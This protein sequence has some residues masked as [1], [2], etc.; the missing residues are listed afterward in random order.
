M[1]LRSQI[2]ILLI[3]FGL[4]PL[5]VALI[6]NLPLI[7]SSLELFYHK[8]HLQNLRADFRDLDQHIASRVEMVRLLA[9]LP[10][11]GVILGDQAE[12]NGMEIN[13]ARKR[14]TEWINRFMF[15]QPDIIQILFLDQ[16]ATAQ[17]WLERDNETLELI[18]DANPLDMPPSEQIHAAMRFKPGGV[19]TS[20]ISI[21][22]KAGLVNPTRHMTLRLISPI[23]A[24]TSTGYPLEETGPP[25]GTVVINIDVGGLARVYHDTHWVLDN[26]NYLRPGNDHGRIG[27]AFE[28]FPGLK[29]IFAE[30]KLALW[31]GEH[32]ER[33]IWVPLFV[34]EKSGPL[35]VGRYVDP[36]PIA[37]FRRKLE[38]RTGLIIFALI[39]IILLIARWIALRTE[40]FGQD[41]ID[42]IRR[43]VNNFEAVKFAWSG[44]QEIQALGKE[45]TQLAKTHAENSAALRAHALE[46]EKSNR[47]KSQFLANVSHELRTPLNS[48]LLL[49]KLLAEGKAI[50]W[51]QQGG[52]SEFP[53]GEMVQAKKLD[54]GRGKS[55]GFVVQNTKHS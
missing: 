44:P 40:R 9:K 32:G 43:V 30:D 29:D 1:K 53:E 8:G 42:G 35:W 25:L 5:A 23:Y 48:I 4:A 16:S 13:K 52:S 37:F 45:L 10:E 21:N 17:F 20:P 7:I 33:V 2:L 46:L 50:F 55:N 38:L 22:P 34:T 39:V 41:L 6:T 51:C 11:P 47:Y 24:P 54:R 18:H 15:D 12:K 27:A 19:L 28:E 3:L 14:Y 31:K 26:G 49:S 36:S